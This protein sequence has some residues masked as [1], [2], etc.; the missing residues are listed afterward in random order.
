MILLR[1]IEVEGARLFVHCTGV[2]LYAPVPRP[3]ALLVHGYPLDHR[4]WL[5]VLQSELATTHTLAAVDLRGHGRSPWTGEAV[6]TMERMADDLAAVART[7]TDDPVDLV[8]LSMGGYAALALCE[9]HPDVVRSLALVDT[10]ATAD[11]ETGKE[12]R[13]TAAQ[14]VVLHG[15]RWLAEQ[16][17][18]KLVAETA[19]HDVRARLQT[20]IESTPVETIVADLEGMRLREDRLHVLATLQKKV[21]C[22]VGAH[23]AL[24]PVSDAKAM[25]DACEH[26]TLAVI[27]GAGHMMPMER[28]AEFHTALAQ[29]WSTR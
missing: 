29:F 19:T 11:S 17:V 26:A 20:M 2:D 14:N 22:A 21:L 24:T 8:A 13:R 4:M 23:D 5:D 12:A 10:K 7:L 16:M 18:P 1:E 15:R 28:P 25:V 3:V 6:H 9:R 27:D